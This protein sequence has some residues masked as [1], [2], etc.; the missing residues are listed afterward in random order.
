MIQYIIRSMRIS[1]WVKNLF[2]LAPLVFSKTLFDADRL[3][4]ATVGFVLL[5]L[6]SSA[7]YLINDWRDK[8]TDRLHPEKSRRP[9]AAGLLTGRA[10]LGAA[11]LLA[12]LGILLALFLLG[13]S[14]ASI[15]ALFFLTG[16]WYSFRLRDVEFLD[17]FV[18]AAL[19]A[20]RVLAGGQAIRVEISEWL[21]A[22][23]FFISLLLALG[24]RRH[25]LLILGAGARRHRKVLGSYSAVLLDQ[26]IALVAAATCVSYLLY[27]LSDY[28]LLKFGTDALFFTSPFVVYGLFRFYAL[29]YDASRDESPT[30]LLLKDVRLRV[31]TL[32]WLLA[33]VALI[34]GRR[35][36][37]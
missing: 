13:Y 19:F 32:L 6:I 24:K 25:E 10:V 29:V 21:L 28:A 17:I 8:E 18:I 16:L 22:A 5:S 31:N 20:L 7:C 30:D 33:I 11:G 2:F 15:F 36:S 4:R 23:T 34:Y 35:F 37:G 27:T 9:I 3:A 26:M 14:T 1:Q 12:A